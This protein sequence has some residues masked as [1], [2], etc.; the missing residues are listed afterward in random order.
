MG[1]TDRSWSDDS[2]E[3]AWVARRAGYVSKAV[4]G[5]LIALAAALALDVSADAAATALGLVGT[6]MRDYA[7][8]FASEE[9]EQGRRLGLADVPSVAAHSVGV[10]LGALP[11]FALF[12]A[13]WL[14]LLAVE[15]TVDLAIWSGIAL[16]FVFGYVAGRL[17]GDTQVAALVH[18]LLLAV[19]GLGVLLIKYII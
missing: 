9:I 14:G 7:P 10:A 16:L 18:A 5:V 12:I 3:V 1:T 11:A 15:T 6:V 19:V 8:A 13:A 4:K 17:Q 2:E